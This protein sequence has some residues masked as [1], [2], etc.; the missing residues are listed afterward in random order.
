MGTT[1]RWGKQISY[2]LR[3]QR[4]INEYIRKNPNATYQEVTE[5]I[6]WYFDE[7][8]FESSPMISDWIFICLDGGLERIER[9][10]N[11]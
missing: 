6:S 9:I 2:D 7:E 11:K 8:E 10:L 1:E 3:A 5:H 4:E